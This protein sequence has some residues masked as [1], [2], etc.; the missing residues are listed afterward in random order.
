MSNYDIVPALSA[1]KR[2]DTA[3]PHDEHD[4]EKKSSSLEG[5][6]D[7]KHGF[8]EPGVVVEEEAVKDALE[9]TEEDLAATEEKLNT[10]TLERTRAIMT[11][12]YTMHKHDQNFNTD[13]LDKMKEFF[14]NPEVF[15]NPDAH[16][17]LITEM[18]LQALLVTENSPYAEVRAN[19]DNTDDPSMPSFTFRVWVIGVIFSGIGA[20]VNELFSIR[21][22]S[23]YITANV[24]QLLAYP[25]GKLMAVALPH[26]TFRLFGRQ[27]SLNPGPFNKKEHMLITIMATVAYNTPYTNYT[28]FVQALPVYFDQPYAKKFGYQILCSMGS[29]FVGF[30]LAGI[31]RKFLVWPSFCVWPASLITVALNKALHTETNEP[32]PGPFKRM[33]TWSREKFFMYA[34]VSMFIYWWF[35]GFIFQNL[36]YFNWMTW[37]SPNNVTL[38]NLTGSLNGLGLNPWPTFDFNTLTVQGWVP[39]VLPTFTILNQLLGMTMAF[40]MILGFYYSNAFESGYL[41]I[42]SNKIFANTGGRYAVAKILNENGEFDNDKYQQYSEPYM[43]AGNLVIYFWFFAIYTATLAYAFLYHYHDIR[44]GFKGAWRAI[45]KRKGTPDDEEDDLAE[46]IHFKLMKVYKEVPEWWYMIVLAL[47]AALGMIGIGVYPTHSSPATVIFGII[48][49]LISIIPVGMI[50]AVTGIQVT[51]NVLAE[52]IGGA[53][54]GGNAVEMNFFKMYGYITTAQA[55]YFCNDLK[56]AHYVKIPP[57]HT[58]V[59]QMTAVLISTFV[60]TGVFNFQLSFKNVCTADAAFGFTCPGQNTFFTASVFWGTL[61]PNRLFGPGRRYN[62]LLIGFPVGFVL[63]FI[64]RFLQNRFPKQQWLRQLHP[65]MICAGGLLWAPYNYANFLPAVYITCFSWLYIKK[66]YLAFWSKYNYVLAAAWMTAI[67]LAAIVIFFGLQIPAIELD[68]WGN[69]A[70]AQGCEGVACPRLE[71]PEV[72]YFGPEPGSGTFI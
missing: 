56:L 65:V 6:V 64:C 12:V 57:R 28:V 36:Q 43:A 44:L 71:V 60:C 37:I 25:L 68:W 47:A 53:M 50:T 10:M 62:A 11:Q 33:Y 1:E 38:S 22:P 18:K 39:M 8:H 69:S 46:D 3:V 59:A 48:M 16:A 31:C 66:R 20:F 7:V 13:A 41:P 58:F 55:I 40:F 54:S 63:P 15:S 51:M 14:D 19:V 23:V 70:Y 21:N 30:G 34:F 9:M 67:A 24:A 29:N 42:N 72:G 5:E 35:P 61:S 4:H 32:V 49:A 26:K 52:F 45:K 27:H 2:Y 17:K